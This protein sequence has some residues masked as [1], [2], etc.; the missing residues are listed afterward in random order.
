MGRFKWVTRWYKKSPPIAHSIGLGQ[1]VGSEY[2]KNKNQKKKKE[3]KKYISAAIY[4][5]DNKITTLLRRGN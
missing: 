4:Q 1:Y 3:K 5:N 2:I